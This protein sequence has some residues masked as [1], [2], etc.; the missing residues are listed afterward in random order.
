MVGGFLFVIAVLAYML[1]ILIVYPLL[2][3]CNA[4]RWLI[5]C[6]NK[7]PAPRTSPY[8]P[9][10]L[11]QDS[12]HYRVA[13]IGAGWTGLQATKLFRDRGIDVD[14]FEAHSDVGGTW[15]P[16]NAYAGLELHSPG[17]LAEF[18]DF[19]LPDE[20]RTGRVS[21]E[22]MQQYNRDFFLTFRLGLS[23]NFY[24]KVTELH[25]DSTTRKSSLVVQSTIDATASPRRYDGYDAVVYTGFSASPKL[26]KWQGQEHFRG[27]IVHCR[28]VSE[29]F[30]RETFG[31]PKKRVMVI[32]GSKSA[33]DMLRVFHDRAAE[34]GHPQIQWL[35]R[36][37]YMFV[38][39]SNMFHG[40]RSTFAQLRSFFS[41]LGWQLVR[42]S[43]FWSTI[44]LKYVVHHILQPK[45]W[46]HCDMRKFHAGVLQPHEIELMQATPRIR[47][48]IDH[49]DSDGRV[50]LKRSGLVDTPDVII[51]ATGFNTGAAHIKLF[52]DG[53]CMNATSTALDDADKEV[54]LEAAATPVAA[55]PHKIPVFEGVFHTECSRLALGAN[56][57]YTYGMKR[58]VSLVDHVLSLLIRQVPDEQMRRHARR[59]MDPET[60]LVFS[61]D[62]VSIRTY[63]Y[64][65]YEELFRSG[66]LRR[67]ELA[68]HMYKMRVLQIHD[69]LQLH[70]PPT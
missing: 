52:R 2:L 47:D 13:V 18:L 31:N 67:I 35:S 14:L 22:R 53:V 24:S 36:S 29:T 17:W 46:P 25:Y 63:F 58:G 66:L 21:A 39:Y 41:L 23:A 19:P 64:A 11:P 1:A 4:F 5:R 57:L 16:S 55:P 49:F 54:D 27:T 60:N 44:F 62:E 70:L 8:R 9:I 68:K 51:C 45:G 10:E 48:E 15:H 3:I 42:I 40:N 34:L 43:T 32:G 28:D 65:G 56:V 69:P 30:L 33:S 6:G 37:D 26:P 50:V 7:P 38:R 12:P 20:I 61:G 59:H